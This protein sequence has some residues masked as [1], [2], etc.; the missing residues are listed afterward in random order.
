MNM[1]TGSKPITLLLNPSIYIAGAR[2]LLLGW[3]AIFLAGL[4]GALSGTHFD[5]VLDVH[6]NPT[7]SPPTPLWFFI[8]EGFIAWLCLT[9]AL[10]MAGKLTAPGGFRVIDL[11]GTQALAR[12]PTMFI[13]VIALL[14]GYQ[15]F[16]G[17]LLDQLLNRGGHIQFV[18]PDAFAFFCVVLVMTVLICW[19]VYLMYKAYSVSCNVTGAKAVVSFIVAVIAAEVCSKTILYFLMRA[20]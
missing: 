18:T 6:T 3:A 16:T 12:W 4:L 8:C 5:G 11:A 9:A 14:P 1:Q 15:R 19:T 7:G 2:A 10:L 17:H 13:S 20:I